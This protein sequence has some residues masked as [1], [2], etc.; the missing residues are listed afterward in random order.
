[1]RY[2]Y[3][4]AMEPQHEGAFTVTVSRTFRKP[5]PRATPRPKHAHAPK[6]P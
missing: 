6:M 3:P 5:S 1:M 4:Y 2:A